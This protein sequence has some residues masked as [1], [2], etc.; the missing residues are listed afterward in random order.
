MD[1]STVITL[2][3]EIQRR[4]TSG[5]YRPE[6]VRKQ[7]YADVRSASASE[8]MAGGQIGLKPDLTFTLF[9]Y[10][11][12]GEELVEYNGVTYTVY[13]TYMARKGDLIELHTQRKTGRNG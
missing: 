5:V 2:V 3:Q 7:V 9:R 1:R 11:Y 12:S 6:M 4:D 8:F 10:D 13:R